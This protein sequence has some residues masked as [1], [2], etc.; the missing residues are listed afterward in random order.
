MNILT[1]FIS[2]LLAVAIPI[3]GFYRAKK[4]DDLEK[5]K[6]DLLWGPS[7]IELARAAGII[8]DDNKNKYVKTTGD[9][10]VARQTSLNFFWKLELLLRKYGVQNLEEAEKNRI[11]EYK[12]LW[13]CHVVKSFGR[14]QRQLS[15]KALAQEQYEETT[16]NIFPLIKSIK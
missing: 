15:S 14:E 12:G 8:A 13:D 7:S 16:M 9:P 4:L 5:E 2:P 3:F 6:K 1:H 11:R 10:D